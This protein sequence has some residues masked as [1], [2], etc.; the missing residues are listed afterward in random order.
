TWTALLSA[1]ATPSLQQGASGDG[2]KRLQRSL[3]AALGTTVGID[4]SFGPA[5]V[6]AVHNYQTS[7]GLT[8]DGIVGPDTWA[9]LQT[10]R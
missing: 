4:G 5:T 1:G 2:V 8:A 9:A 6:T 7:R 3:T 10:G